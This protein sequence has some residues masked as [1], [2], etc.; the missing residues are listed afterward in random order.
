MLRE[1]KSAMIGVWARRGARIC[2]ISGR[3]CDLLRFVYERIITNALIEPGFCN[4]GCL[5]CPTICRDSR[6]RADYRQ[7]GNF[8]LVNTSPAVVTDC[9]EECCEQA[10]SCRRRG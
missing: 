6:L 5:S 4:E 9:G 1:H 10:G 8:V 7:F 3:S 2:S